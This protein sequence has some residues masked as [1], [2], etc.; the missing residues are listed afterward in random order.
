MIGTVTGTGRFRM[1]DR[2]D[3]E[4][5]ADIPASSLDDDAPLYDRPRAGAGRAGPPAAPIGRMPPDPLDVGADLLELLRRPHV[6]V[7]PVRPPA[8]PQH[9]RRARAATPPS[10]G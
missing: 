7:P 3:G 9:G 10:C 6:G 1:L 5:L 4:V 2:L 8:V